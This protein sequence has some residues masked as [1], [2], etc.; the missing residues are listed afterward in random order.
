VFGILRSL[1]PQADSGSR[2]GTGHPL[3][4]GAPMVT[5]RFRTAQRIAA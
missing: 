5:L 2:A 4:I 3:D 1:Q